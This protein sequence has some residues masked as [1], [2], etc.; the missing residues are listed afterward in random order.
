MDCAGVEQV[1]MDMAKNQV[2]VTGTMDIKAL[3]GTLQKKVWRPVD[4]VQPNKEKD[5]EKQQDVG[6]KEKE[7]KPEGW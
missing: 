1:A 2:T 4:V 5:K 6:S 3:P 7:N